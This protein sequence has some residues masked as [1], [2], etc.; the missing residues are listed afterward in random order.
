MTLTPTV[1]E[2]A[3]P[4]EIAYTSCGK[5]ND[6]W[7][8]CEIYIAQAYGDSPIRLTNNNYLDLSPSWS[9]DGSRIAFVTERD[10]NSE[11]YVMNAEGSGKLI[12]QK[13]LQL[14]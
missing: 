8:S 1:S 11:I 13:T 14:I 2:E 7:Q 6:D 9:P 5:G 4:G 3:Y 12:L 10:G